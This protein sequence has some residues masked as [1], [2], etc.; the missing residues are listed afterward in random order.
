M[1]KIKYFLF[2]TICFFP[3]GIQATVE[4]WDNMIIL[5]EN[6][7]PLQWEHVNV[8]L[9]KID[10]LAKE[11]SKS[12]GL[13]VPDWAE[14]FPQGLNMEGSVE[15]ILGLISID[16]C[17]WSLKNMPEGNYVCDFYAKN[18]QDENVR[19]SAAMTA[20]AKKA[21][22]KGIKI[23]D[24][25]FMQQIT[26]DGLRP[27]FMGF[28]IE[29]NAMEIP[30]LE[31]R[32]QVMN[33]IGGILHE[34]WSG[35]FYQIL[36]ASRSHAFNEGRGFVELLVRDFPR[37]RDEYIYRDKKIAIYK[38]AQLAVM[39]LQSSL[40]LYENFQPF[41][42]CD[43]LTLCADYQLP[44]SL[45]DLGILEYDPALTQA[46]DQ[47]KLIPTGSSFE[48]ELRMA[49]V[50]AGWQLKEKI[51]DSLSEIGKPLITSQELDY[52]L[53]SHGRQLDRNSSK[54]HLTRTIMY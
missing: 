12:D 34:K 23:F 27:Y 6:F 47:E 14:V 37:F 39:A 5:M 49:T 53:W 51:N 8:N 16:F 33:E 7:D 21:Y 32:V 24:A 9:E 13:Q 29:G 4:K 54:H 26:A 18:D 45:R 31:N 41:K 46:V 20:L 43:A 10:S 48:I 22:Q 11:L 36:Y 50:F 17:H 19:G 30:E 1:S 52:L 44:R 35:S 2:A 40:R 42:D 3:I 38:L 15:F 25:N 28:D